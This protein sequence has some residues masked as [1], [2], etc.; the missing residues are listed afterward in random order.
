MFLKIVLLD[1]HYFICFL[2]E[3]NR[4]L[5]KLATSVKAHWRRYR[6]SSSMFIYFSVLKSIN[7]FS[8]YEH[9]S[10]IAVTNEYTRVTDGLKN[11]YWRFIF[12]SLSPCALNSQPDSKILTPSTPPYVPPAETDK[13]F[14]VLCS[15]SKIF[16]YEIELK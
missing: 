8:I 6:V 15:V 10:C 9:G 3:A 12:L 13:Y 1:L 14:I 11:L 16:V 7:I 5:C 2:V 4:S